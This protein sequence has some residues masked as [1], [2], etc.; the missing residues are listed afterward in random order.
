MQQRKYNNMRMYNNIL[1][2]DL[3]KDPPDCIAARI[4]LGTQL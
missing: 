2:D 4:F 1:A 3:A